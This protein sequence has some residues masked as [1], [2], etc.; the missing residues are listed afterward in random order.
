MT[1][2]QNLNYQKTKIFF[3]SS[4]FFSGLTVLW[5]GGEKNPKP[6]T[7]TLTLSKWELK[8][9]INSSTFYVLHMYKLYWWSPKTGITQLVLCCTWEEDHSKWGRQR[10]KCFCFPWATGMPE[11]GLMVAWR[12]AMSIHKIRREPSSVG[13]KPDLPSKTELQLDCFFT[14]LAQTPW[15]SCDSSGQA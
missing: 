3:S 12:W 11:E 14:N 13:Y 2:K 8:S 10:G 7:G 4:F 15:Y 6:N 5:G 9:F 1:T